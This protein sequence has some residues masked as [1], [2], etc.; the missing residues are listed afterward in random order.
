MCHGPY[1]RGWKQEGSTNVSLRP[2]YRPLRSVA[3]E[4][5]QELTASPNRDSVVVHEDCNVEAQSNA[6]CPTKLADPRSYGPP[7]NKN[8]GGH[9]AIERTPE[10]IKVWFW[11]RGDS[12]I[13]EEVKDGDDEIDTDTWVGSLASVVVKPTGNSPLSSYRASPSPSF[14]LTTATSMKSLVPRISSLT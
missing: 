12:D 9:Y 11:A 1:C 6:G 8:G 3:Q 10:F 2:L 13:P 14:Q 7:F 4:N 5:T